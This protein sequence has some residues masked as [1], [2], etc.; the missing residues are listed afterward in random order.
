MNAEKQRGHN[1][2]YKQSARGQQKAREWYARNRDAICAKRREK[3]VGPEFR[4]YRRGWQLRT[5][6]GITTEHYAEMLAAQNVCD[7]RT[8]AQGGAATRR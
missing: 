8:G 2:A 3:K 5:R 7:L 6:Y 1:R 4:E